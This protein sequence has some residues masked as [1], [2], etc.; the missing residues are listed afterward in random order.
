MRDNQRIFLFL[1]A[2]FIAVALGSII[3]LDDSGSAFNKSAS[4]KGAETAVLSQSVVGDAG[5]DASS[6]ASSAEII[7]AAAEA[8][9]VEVI[10]VPAEEVS[11][12]EEVV[13]EAA[14][15]ATSEPEEVV[16]EPSIKYYTFTVN[17]KT[18][19]LRLRE[20]PSENA[21]ITNKLA[22]S[23]KGYVLKP[24]NVWCK[25]ITENGNTGYCATSYLVLEEVSE[26]DFPEDVR[27]Q[28]E[29]PDEELSDAFSN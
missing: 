7:V 17:T 1:F 9:S 5:A 27:S 13:E 28:V 29:A 23:T 15:E 24:G 11:I 14:T 18:T 12:I 4:S 10:D 21:T 20:E 25:V 6:Q 22:K 16:E 3:V 26:S 19:I 2:F 8:S